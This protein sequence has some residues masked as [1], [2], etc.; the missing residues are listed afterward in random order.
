MNDDEQKQ[1][2]Y[3]HKYLEACAPVRW[4]NWVS[5]CD[6]P[7]EKQFL[8]SILFKDGGLRD[9]TDETVKR[10]VL[11]AIRQSPSIMRIVI[12][13]FA[14]EVRKQEGLATS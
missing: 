5:R 13:D 12:K 11:D 14:D 1:W 4:L 2:E 7:Q 3:I 6:D 8:E 10:E 9:L